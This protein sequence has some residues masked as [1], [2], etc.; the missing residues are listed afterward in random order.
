MSGERDGLLSLAANFVRGD[1]TAGSALIRAV[2]GNILGAVRT[3]LGP[4]HCDVEDAAQ[5]A[6]VGFLEGLYRFRGE[7]SVRHF[8]GRVAVLTAVSVRRRR[9]ARDRWV[10]PGEGE[11]LCVPAAPESS[12]LVQLEE[13]RRRETMRKMLDE[14]PDPVAEAIALHFMLGYTV[15]EVAAAAVVPVNTV[16]SRLRIG[17]ERMRLRMAEDERGSALRAFL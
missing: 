8:A 11:E 10:V 14:L 17:K 3:V 7:C 9:R 12:P 5:D 6:V 1:V 2:S 15:Q 4:G 13:S 16:W